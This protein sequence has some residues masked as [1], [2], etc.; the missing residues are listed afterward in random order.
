MAALLTIRDNI[1]NFISKYDKFITPVVKFLIYLLMF[2][3]L[4]HI[5]GYNDTVSS[6]LIIFLLSA[7]CAFMTEGIALALGGIFACAQFF[8]ASKEIAASFLIIFVLMYCI[9]IR[10]F[11][12]TAWLIMFAPLFFIFKMQYLLPVI[13]GMFAGPAGIIS[14]AFG[15]IFY[16][17]TQHTSSYVILMKVTDEEDMIEG[18]KY[19]FQHLIEDKNLILTM[20]VF[21]VII[22]ITAVIYR[23]SFDYSWYAAIIVGG[24]FEIILF[25]IGNFAL[26]ATLSIAGILL[27]SITAII[28]SIIVQFFKVVVDYSRTEITQFEDDEY[29]YYVKAVPKVTMAKTKK[30][31]R[32]ISSGNVSSNSGKVL[33]DEESIHGVTR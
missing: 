26:E 33:E 13:A 12:K 3:S 23:L 6:G 22:V 2:W 9:Y 25:M 15:C 32:T 21:A 5:T 10:F 24:L 28:I 18:Y 4:N 14:A 20:V 29:Y 11:P 17:F 19:M 16:Y 30:N 27:G 1:R 7:V 8:S 31:V